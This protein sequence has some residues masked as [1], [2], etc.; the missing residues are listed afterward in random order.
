[1]MDKSR[2]LSL[3]SVEYSTDAIGQ[4]IP[5][6]TRR[7]VFCSIESI[8]QN[9][10][11]EAGRHGLRAE[12]RAVMFYPE[13]HGEEICELGGVRYGIYRTYIRKNEEIELYLERK[14]GV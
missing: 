7:D 6:E 11:Y 1:M 3:I 13:Y 14:S 12:H 5:T 2:I 8:T 9:E 10:F 4:K